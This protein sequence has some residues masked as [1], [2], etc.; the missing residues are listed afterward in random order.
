MLTCNLRCNS[1][2]NYFVIENFSGITAGL[3]VGAMIMGI[4]YTTG[5]L[6][7]FQ[8]AKMRFFNR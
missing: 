1:P 5:V 3:A 8:A 7:K 6:T 4:L 2:D